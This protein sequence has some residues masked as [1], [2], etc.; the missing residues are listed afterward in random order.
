MQSLRPSRVR[1]RLP[2]LV[3]SVVLLVSSSLVACSDSTGPDLPGPSSR[4]VLGV[5]SRHACRLSDDGR[6]LCWGR[7]DAGQLGTGGTPL[8]STPVQAAA[9][10]TRFASIAVGGLHTC[11]LTPEGE[12]WCWGANN[13][14]QAGLPQAITGDCGEP[15]HGWECVPLPHAVE[16]ALRF[17]ALVAGAANT[18]GFT[19]EGTVHCW[20]SNAAGQLGA[21]ASDTCDG[22]PCSRVPV[23]LAGPELRAVALGSAAHVCGL[24]AEGKAYCWGSNADGQL[25]VGTLGGSRAVPT[26]VAGEIRYRAIA[27]GGQHTCALSTDGMPWCWGRD[28]LPPGEGGVSLSATP[29]RIEGSPAFADLITGTWAACGRRATGAVHCWGINANG[30]MGITPVGLNTRISTPQPMAGNQGWVTIAGSS[31]TFCG[32][33][34]AGDTWCW[35]HGADGELG[36]VLPYSAMPVLIDGV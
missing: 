26:P 17:D 6:V 10:S 23:S 18:C 28:I 32:L 16:T 1:R 14:G 34:A 22:L 12:A 3:A 5:G 4:V 35:G 2:S 33:D 19:E 25:G 21:T 36:P 11:A 15:I 13:A 9:G 7:A 29:V 20:G 8:R 24:T 27:V 30:E 31:G